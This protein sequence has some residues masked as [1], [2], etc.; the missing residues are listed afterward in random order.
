MLD[1]TIHSK[2]LVRH[3]RKADFR[4]P[5]WSIGPGDKEAVVSEAKQIAVDGFKTVSLKRNT[6]GNK[7]VYRQASLAEALLTRHVSD[8]IRRITSVRQ[9]D[10][11]AI[12]KSLVQLCSE[13][14]PFNV[15][16]MDIKS[17]Y[18]SVDV[19]EIILALKTDAAFSRQSV[20]VLESFFASLAR[21]QV[22]G[23]P[24]GIGLSATLAEY[25]M[26]NFDRKIGGHTGV[27]YY[28]RYVDDSIAVTSIDVDPEELIGT[29]NS[30]LPRGLQLNRSKT[31]PFSLGASTRNTNGALEQTIKFLGYEIF[32]H[33]ICSV[34]KRL[35]REV[36]VDIAKSK[37]AR[38]K[39]RLAKSFLEFNS[40]G[41]FDDLLLRV[42][43]LTSNFGYV[44]QASGMQR[45][46]G[47]RYNYGLINPEESASLSSLDRFLRNALMSPHPNNRIRPH[48][49][50]A[51]R[52]QLLGLSF[53]SG[54]K[55]NRFFTFEQDQIERLISCWSHA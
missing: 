9:S 41:R 28:S 37:V 44:D 19:Q 6:I 47:L 29:A 45:Y 33:Q 54:F 36:R 49:S 5:L 21:Q 55:S 30:L 15:V 52:H 31:K 34:E 14:I 22:T 8:S 43:L 12:V 10:R 50:R 38:I 27:R 2:T 11:N 40:H 17:F 48:L 20:F 39:R 4:S 51:Q 18:E 7:P 13:G 46:V 25:V 35:Q 3:F 26:R 16:K 53:S 23:L 42:K 24:R 1:S 32:V